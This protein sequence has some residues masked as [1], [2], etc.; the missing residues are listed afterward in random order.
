MLLFWVL[1]ILLAVIFWHPGFDNHGTRKLA[2]RAWVAGELFFVNIYLFFLNTNS[3]WWN[4]NHFLCFDKT[5][6]WY[7]QAYE[8]CLWDKAMSDTIL[9][10][11]KVLIDL[12]ATIELYR[13]G[14]KFN[15]EDESDPTAVYAG[16]NPI[17]CMCIPL[18]NKL[19]YAFAGFQT[20]HVISW[21]IHGLVEGVMM[22]WAFIIISLLIFN[23]TQYVI[24]LTSLKESYMGRMVLFVAFVIT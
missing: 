13:W 7:S 12:W 22:S 11:V 15:K 10:G 20:L 6:N 8:D 5:G 23:I 2:F 18:G 3:F 17:V 14:S 1:M 9:V 21:V 4:A 19:M 24:V 16:R